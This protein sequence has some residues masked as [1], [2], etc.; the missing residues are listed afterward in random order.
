M[1]TFEKL[2]ELQFHLTNDKVFLTLVEYMD[3]LASEEQKRSLDVL[4]VLSMK[5]ANAIGD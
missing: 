1:S 2:S 3:T 4:L 5:A